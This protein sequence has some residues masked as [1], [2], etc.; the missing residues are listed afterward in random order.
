MC[1]CSEPGGGARVSEEVLHEHLGRPQ[2]AV[3]VP[4]GS[5]VK[6]KEDVA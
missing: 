6:A 1:R 3:L 4:I 2:H 5:A